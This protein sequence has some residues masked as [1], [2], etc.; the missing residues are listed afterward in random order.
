MIMKLEM[1]EMTCNF[2]IFTFITTN[3]KMVQRIIVIIDLII[4]TDYTFD[5]YKTQYVANN[6]EN[7]VWYS[8]FFIHCYEENL[9][10]TYGN[11]A[12]Y[13]TIPHQKEG[14]LE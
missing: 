4:L 14:I 12:Y 7:I 8:L 2:F 1:I 10:F 6:S 5:A 3:S 13:I 11:D 9:L